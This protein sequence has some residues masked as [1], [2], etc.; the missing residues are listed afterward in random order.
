MSSATA[1]SL[2][3]A[4][5]GLIVFSFCIF[6]AIRASKKKAAGQSAQQGTPEA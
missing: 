6:V 2:G 3:A 4:A 1:I 5:I